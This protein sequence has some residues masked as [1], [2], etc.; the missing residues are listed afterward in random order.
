MTTEGEPAADTPE[1]GVARD[2]QGSADTASGDRHLGR[3]LIQIGGLR[4][5]EGDL[6]GDRRVT[7]AVDVG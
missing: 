3:R 6:D 2:Y 5:A 1:A 4:V 7:V